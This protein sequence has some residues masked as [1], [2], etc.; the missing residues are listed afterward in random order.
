MKKLL[1][2]ITVIISIIFA[3]DIYI[4]K[5]KENHY[6]SLIGLNIPKK[7]KVTKFN[8]SHGG[9]H[10]DGEL[11]EVIQLEQDDIIYF[12]QDALNTGSWER[13]PMDKDLRKFIYGEYT[14]KYSHGGYGEMMPDDIV[15]GLYYFKDRY[16]TGEY[17]FDRP[18]QNF[19]FA[20]LD[21]NKGRLYILKY[22]S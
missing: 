2:I 4:E 18:S 17:I 20:L 3:R 5:S 14:S 16:R 6:I 12:M 7:S 1:I 19:N 13:L 9:F 21:I 8:D 10:G 22:D 11:F 15:N